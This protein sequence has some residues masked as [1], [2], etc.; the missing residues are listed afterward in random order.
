M[1]DKVISIVKFITH[2][3]TKFLKCLKTNVF[4]VCFWRRQNQ[5]LSYLFFFY[6]DLATSFNTSNQTKWCTLICQQC[7][8]K[9]IKKRWMPR[10]KVG[11]S[12]SCTHWWEKRNLTSFYILGLFQTI[13]AN[14]AIEKKYST[15]MHFLRELFAKTSG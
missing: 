9:E 5:A 12:T 14:V 10:N 13:T 4:S 11:N 1:H 7:L 3:N 8:T 2:I 15:M 6:K